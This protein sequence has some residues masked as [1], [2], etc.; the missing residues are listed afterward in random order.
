M[1]RG[2]VCVTEGVQLK[3]ESTIKTV[4]YA[5]DQVLTTKSEG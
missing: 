1:E 3:N 5:D 4:L 2:C